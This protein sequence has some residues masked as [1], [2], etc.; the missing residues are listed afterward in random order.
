MCLIDFD[1]N[2]V[3]IQNLYFLESGSVYRANKSVVNLP[4]WYHKA[5]TRAAHRECSRRTCT[6]TSV[7]STCIKYQNKSTRLN[8]LETH[9]ARSGCWTTYSFD[10]SGYSDQDPYPKIRW[11]GSD[12]VP[13]ILAGRIR[14]LSPRGPGSD[15]WRKGIYFNIRGNWRKKRI[16]RFPLLLFYRSNIFNPSIIWPEFVGEKV[17]VAGESRHGAGHVFVKLVDLLRV[18]NL[19]KK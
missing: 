17:G 18:E 15:L 5:R 13:W 6:C 16:F 4:V 12:R 7:R 19:E 2:I 10:N 9:H 3:K 14:N 11:W 8:R 1:Y